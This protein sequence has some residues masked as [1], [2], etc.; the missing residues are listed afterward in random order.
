MLFIFIGSMIAKT[1]K[2]PSKLIVAIGFWQIQDVKPFLTKWIDLNIRQKDWNTLL[3][4]ACFWWHQDIVGL[5]L[6]NGANV[7]IQDNTWK[8]ALMWACRGQYSF[9]IDRDNVRLRQIWIVKLLLENGADI[10]ICDNNW[11]TALMWAET[12][13]YKEMIKLLLK[14]KKK[15]GIR[16]IW[17][18][19]SSIFTNKE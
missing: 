10:N 17:N 19:L 2:Y 13:W 4:D 8:T 9:L 18:F 5:L 11:W 15:G 6:E 12:S 14:Y 3:I 1:K 7:N 16:S